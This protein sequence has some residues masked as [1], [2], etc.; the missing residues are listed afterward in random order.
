VKVLARLV[1]HMP[2]RCG[3]RLASTC[4]LIDLCGDNVKHP[5]GWQVFR[6]NATIPKASPRRTGC[7]TPPRPA[8]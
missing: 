2:H 5:A 4:H 1:P 8:G 6:Q 7:E 3:T